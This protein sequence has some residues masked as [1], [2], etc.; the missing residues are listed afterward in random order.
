[1]RA[2]T[3][4]P[5]PCGP[6]W[7]APARRFARPSPGWSAA[8]GRI[9]RCAMNSPDPHPTDEQ[10][11]AL[12]GATDRAAPPPDRAVLD[13]L[14]EQSLDAFQGAAAPSA[15]VSPRKPLMSLSSFRW[16]AAVAAVLVVGVVLAQ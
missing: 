2:S 5:R 1:P 11:A 8:A 3:V 9:R 12:L 13:R 10:L 14:R 15:P 7:R 4:R 6:S 16:V